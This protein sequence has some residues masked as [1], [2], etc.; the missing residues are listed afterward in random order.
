MTRFILHDIALCGEAPPRRAR[1]AAKGEDRPG[2]ACPRYC[3]DSAGRLRPGRCQGLVARAARA[4]KR[5]SSLWQLAPG[6][7]RDWPCHHTD[8]PACY[9]D[10]AWWKLVRVSDGGPKKA[11]NVHVPHMIAN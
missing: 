3:A 1:D 8:K 2:P 9:R 4:A 5:R 7:R 10:R 6:C 11:A